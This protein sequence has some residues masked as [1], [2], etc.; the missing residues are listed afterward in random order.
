MTNGKLE[1]SDI[2]K[3]FRREGWKPMDKYFELCFIAPDG[4]L[5]GH[6]KDG[7][8]RLFTSNKGF[9]CYENAKQKKRIEAAP[10]VIKVNGIY[11]ITADRFGNIDD[12]TKNITSA[13]GGTFSVVKFPADWD[14]VKKVW[15]YEF[16]E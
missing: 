4:S 15:F 12:I 10:A 9:V 5:F 8:S 7:N 3:K 14:D 13:Y 6:D 11:Q 1:I 16:E 2:G